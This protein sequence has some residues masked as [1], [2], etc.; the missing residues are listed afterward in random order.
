[1]ITMALDRL[2]AF[3]RGDTFRVVVESPR[4][5]TV[6]LK[7]DPDIGAMTLARPL[8]FGVAYPFDWG[9]VPGTEMAD[10]DPLDVMVLWDTATY[11][12]V[13]L[14]C[15]ALGVVRV[16]Q[17]KASGKG[18]ERNDR[19]LAI[20]VKAPR[21]DRLRTPADLPS[22]DRQELEQFFFHVTALEHKDIEILGW[23]G[24]DA[25]LRLIRRSLIT[26]PRAGE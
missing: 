2:P 13:V 24:P 19:V 12:G 1:M 14:P 4:G 18:R 26:E 21:A 8:T 10:G 9:F 5:S 11:P 3:V 20:P 23:S 7:F 22:R 25:A 17:K 15:R 16:S 6:K